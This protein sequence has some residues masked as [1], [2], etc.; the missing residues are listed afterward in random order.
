MKAFRETVFS[1]RSYTP[2]PFL[3]V[4]VVFAEPTPVSML[5]GGILTIL[6]ELVRSW[7][8]AYAGPLTRVTGSVGAPELIVAGPFARVRNPLYVGNMVMYV[9][10]GIMANA[11][12][13]WLVLGAGVFFLT[14]YT[15]IVT[16]EEEFLQKQFGETFTVYRKSVPRFLPR[17]TP[18]TLPGQAGQRP[19]WGAGFRSERRTLQALVLVVLLI[20]VRWVWN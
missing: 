14:Q 9:G 5:A 20:V 16:L 7:G 3:V 6:G 1:C 11:L 2:L 17:W 13:P 18:A 15:I 8:V 19:D 12:T 4:M 10:F